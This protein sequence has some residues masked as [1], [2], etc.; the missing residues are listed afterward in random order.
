MPTL[1]FGG[2][3]R[4]WCKTF[5]PR[6][7]MSSKVDF[8]RWT[9]EIVQDEAQYA[10]TISSSLLNVVIRLQCFDCGWI[11]GLDVVNSWR[12]DES[13]RLDFRKHQHHG[14]MF[15]HTERLNSSVTGHYF[16]L[17]YALIGSASLCYE[18]VPSVLVLSHRSVVVSIIVEAWRREFTWRPL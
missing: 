11:G 1:S 8:F 6:N 16:S 12:H 9:C 18:M 4:Q 15:G 2:L 5:L 13:V 17:C 7:V 10:L 3:R 14:V